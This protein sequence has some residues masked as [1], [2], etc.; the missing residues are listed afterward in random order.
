MKRIILWKDGKPYLFCI[1]KSPKR[2]E[3][4]NGGWVLILDG[5]KGIV[6]QTKMELTFDRMTE[7]PK[8]DDYNDVME[9]AKLAG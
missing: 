6:E 5:L 3:V 2:W 8:G 7:A 1:R 4:I 9:K